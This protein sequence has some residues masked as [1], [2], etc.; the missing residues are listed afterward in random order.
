MSDTPQGTAEQVSHGEL[1][2]QVRYGYWFN[3][4]CERL[5]G[6]IDL[7]LNFVQL[8]GGSAVA[9][10]SLQSYPRVA[11]VAGLFLAAAAAVSLL[12]APAVKAERHL[13]AKCGYLDL[14]ARAWDIQFAALMNELTALRRDAPGGW[15]VLAVPAFNATVR[16]IGGTATI[17]ET[18]LQRFARAI[19]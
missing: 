5:Y 14:E 17:P 19:A 13:R 12:M 10:A 18:R 3:H 11:T 16:A 6:R 8:V 2:S 9:V 1:V 15:D 4:L 7:V